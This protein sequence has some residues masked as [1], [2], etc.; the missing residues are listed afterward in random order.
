MRI[1]VSCELAHCS[2]DC[3]SICIPSSGSISTSPYSLWHQANM[4]S[5]SIACSG[6]SK[7][8]YGPCPL[9][10]PPHWSLKPSKEGILGQNAR[11]QKPGKEFGPNMA[12]LDS[13]SMSELS[14]DTL[15][16]AL[17]V[18]KARRHFPWGV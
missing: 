9:F 17:H 3:R 2:S 1:S 12:F 14:T 16:Q 10:G 4:P 5:F 18:T 6:L 15:F 7:S 8:A 13:L 11:V